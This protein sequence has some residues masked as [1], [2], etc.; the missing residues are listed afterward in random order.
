M[1]GRLK[2][3]FV[4]AAAAVLALVGAGTT[5][6]AASS[7]TPKAGGEC[8]KVQYAKIVKAAGKSY[9]CIYD[10]KTKKY[11]WQLITKA[12]TTVTTVDPT[13]VDKT[14]WPSKF[15]IGGVPAENVAAMQTKWQG[16]VKLFQ[17]ELGIPVEFYAGTSYAGVIEASIANKVDMV[18]WGAMSYIV[19]K[20]NG[21]KIEPVAISK[22]VDGST[23]Y[24]SKLWVKSDST[25]AGIKDL[26]GKKVCF[27]TQTSTSGG[28]IPTEGILNAGLTEKDITQNWTGGHDK[29]MLGLST[30][31]CE[32]AF[33]CCVV[34]GTGTLAAMKPAEYKQIW[35]SGPI[36][37]GPMSIRSTLPAS[38]K[39]A[40]RN[41]LLTKGNKE[42]FVSKGYNGCT[43][44]ATC[45]V[46]EDKNVNNF[47]EVKDSFYDYIRGVCEATKSSSCKA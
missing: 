12:T 36:P 33:S 25:I 23:S 38:F 1:K 6:V 37:N 42:Y 26:K 7:A 8:T 19:S 2:L 5:S 20:L 40:V 43:D 46:V 24:T 44:I 45:V 31:Q 32:A 21:A 4:V 35:E 28:L 15:V 29:S 22:Y 3:K 17:D 10:A 13:K 41:I 9:R 27:V 47:V 30:N 11:R 18:A 34:I 14:G 16:L 39:A